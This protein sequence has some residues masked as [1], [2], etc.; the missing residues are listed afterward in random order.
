MTDDEFRGLF[1]DNYPLVLAYG[2]RRVDADTARDVAAETFLVAW[3]RLD[4]APEQPHAWLLAVARRVLANELRRQGR[5]NGLRE[6]LRHEVVRAEQARDDHDS[7]T[8]D[9]VHEAMS[10]LSM[11]DRELLVLIGWEQL[12]QR[13]AAEV[14]GCSVAGEGSAPPGAPTAG[15]SPSVGDEG[16]GRSIRCPASRSCRC[17]SARRQLCES[18][19]G[20]HL[21][22]DLERVRRLIGPADPLA[23]GHI[24]SAADS[25]A[26]RA[27]L[28]D[29]VA[30]PRSADEPSKLRSPQSFSRRFLLNTGLATGMALIAG[31]LVVFGPGLSET[32]AQAATPP[33]LA[34]SGQGTDGSIPLQEMAKTAKSLPETNISGSFRYSWT[35]TWALET[36]VSGSKAKSRL[37]SQQNETWLRGD[38]TGRLRTAEGTDLTEPINGNLLRELPNLPER[39]D[40]QLTPNMS[41]GRVLQPPADLTEIDTRDVRAFARTVEASA[42]L[43]LPEGALVAEAIHTLFAEQPVPAEVRAR[44]WRLLATVPGVSYLGQ[45]RDRAGRSGIAI[46]LDD[47][48]TAHGLPVRYLLV[49]DPN[50]GQLLEYDEILTSDPGKLNVQIPSVLEVTLYL[51]RGYVD[52]STKRPTQ[53]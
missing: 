24:V 12:D 42:N 28:E 3:R 9:V 31:G 1:R 38:G 10:T 15:D 52:S 21:M 32:S 4:A 49:I 39:S 41:D 20:V 29:I 37:L 34:T 8:I 23:G 5:A 33:L 2:L 27:T 30:Q 17:A 18:V 16:S 45:T 22:N 40:Q 43:D 14:L 36:T 35:E 26:A 44:I 47:D 13:A 25:P 50:D 51:G 53:S 6:K 19:E 46:A 48:G 7:D 11:R